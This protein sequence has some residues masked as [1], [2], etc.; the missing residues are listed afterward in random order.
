MFPNLVREGNV[1]KAHGFYSMGG[2]SL[3]THISIEMLRKFGILY[4]K[5]WYADWNDR[6]LLSIFWSLNLGNEPWTLEITHPKPLVEIL[7]VEVH[8]LGGK[9]KKKNHKLYVH[10]VVQI[11]ILWSDTY[12]C[13]D[14]TTFSSIDFSGN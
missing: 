6:G 2:Q 7:K 5:F 14:N 1:A 8:F 9:K 3:C 10:V 13:S 4:W 11:L 12:F